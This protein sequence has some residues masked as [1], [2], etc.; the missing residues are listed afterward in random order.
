MSRGA[1]LLLNWPNW[2]A[3]RAG[4]M[5]YRYISWGELVTVFFMLGNFPHYYFFFRLAWRSCLVHRTVVGRDIDSL[6]IQP[7]KE[8]FFYFISLFSLFLV[9]KSVYNRHFIPRIPT[10]YLL[11]WNFLKR[12]FRKLR[13]YRYTY[14]HNKS[15]PLHLRD[16]ERF[17][18]FLFH[19]L[20]LIYLISCFWIE[21]RA[22]SARM[23]RTFHFSFLFFFLFQ[24]KKKIFSILFLKGNRSFTFILF[25]T[26][27]WQL[28]V[29]C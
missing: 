1:R 6:F 22:T 18:S 23:N 27:L 11:N 14:L 16:S 15:L 19:N 26:L 20:R 24:H 5:K 28:A 4:K 25:F 10:Y 8:T 7:Q 17:L 3:E 12:L 21:H 2:L 9:F 13:S 29:S